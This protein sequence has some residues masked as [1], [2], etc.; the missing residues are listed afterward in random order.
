MGVRIADSGQRIADEFGLGT[1]RSIRYAAEGMMAR[2]WRLDATSGSYAV[3][4]FDGADRYELE[5]KLEY[6]AGLA[7]AATEAGVLAPRA[8]RSRVGGLVHQAA[9]DAPVVVSVATWVEGRPC[10]LR[11]DAADAAP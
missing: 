9:G 8:V 4:E 10:D 11:R 6:S 2:I 1:A 7:D 5:A 3:K